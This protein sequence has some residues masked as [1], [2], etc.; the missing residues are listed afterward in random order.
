MIKGAIFDLDGTLL[1]S[2][3]LWDTIGNDYLRSLGIETNE[4]LAETFKTFTLE[5]SA[6][7]YRTH[8]G[9]TLSVNEIING[10]N[11]IIM[12]FYRDV[13]PLKKG[14]AEFLERLSRNGVK[15]CIATVTGKQLAESALLRLNIRNYFSEIFTVAEIGCGKISPQIYRTALAHLGTKKCET[16]VFEDAYHAMMTAKN[17]GFPVAAVYD[18][19]ETMQTEMQENSDYYIRNYIKTNISQNSVRPGLHSLS[20]NK[21]NI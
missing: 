10:I 12:D 16:L 17:D 4:N 3:S 9:I 21:N 1:D 13:V 20:L 8:Y 5:Q 19:H 11:D 15:M 14:A 2:M 6:E 18:E 7:Y